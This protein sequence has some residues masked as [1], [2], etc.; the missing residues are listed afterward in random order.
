MRAR[1][2]VIPAAGLGTRFYPVTKAVPKELLPIV[3]VPA[4]QLIMDEAIDA[5]CD[6]IVLVS[7]RA[8]PGLENYVSPDPAVVAKLR[9]LGRDAV[10]DRLA[11]IGTDVRVTITYQENPRGLGH[12]VGCARDAVGDESFAVLLPDELRGDAGLLRLLIDSSEATGASAIELKRVPMDEVS[13]YGVVSVAAGAPADGPFE[14][15]DVVEKPKKE[16]APSD[17]IILGRYVLTPGIWEDI[18]ALQPHPNGELQLTDALLS[19]TK[20]VPILGHLTTTER[21][22][23]GTPFGWL[24]AVIDIALRRGDTGPQLREWLA[25]RL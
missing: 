25:R 20:R 3:D 17:L 4:L 16:D 7:S 6:H 8:K 22:D 10:A 12:A 21:Y 1:T 11:R 18:E 19:Q 13:A 15:T 14:I 5:G 23:T 24:T 2:A 9:D